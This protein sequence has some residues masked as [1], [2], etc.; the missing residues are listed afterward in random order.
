MTNQVRRKNYE[1]IKNK[2]GVNEMSLIERAKE[3]TEEKMEG[4]EDKVSYT[5]YIA[6][7]FK[8]EKTKEEIEK[9]RK[10]IWTGMYKMLLLK[11]WVVDDRQF[12]TE[13]IGGWYLNLLDYEFEELLEKNEEIRNLD[14]KRLR[15]LKNTWEQLDK[16]IKEFGIDNYKG[17]IEQN[18]GNILINHFIHQICIGFEFF[19]QP[20]NFNVL[21]DITLIEALVE[22]KA[23]GLKIHQGF[24]SKNPKKCKYSYLTAMVDIVI[25][26]DSDIVKVRSI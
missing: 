15:I 17:S 14:G 25:E 16:D 10:N 3:Y 6:E 8:R 9:L 21:R 23:E 26:E 20:I 19:I 7:F 11:D 18:R 4:R 1:V 13:E 24:T 22:L 2:E 5:N 12:F